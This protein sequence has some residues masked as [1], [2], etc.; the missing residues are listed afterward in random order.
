MI[1]IKS[2]DFTLFVT[3]VEFAPDNFPSVRTEITVSYKSGWLDG[4]FSLKSI[5]FGWDAI[6]DFK[7]G[8]ES[9]IAG[10]CSSVD[11]RDMSDDF[12]FTLSKIESGVGI[13]IEGGQRSRSF[14]F[15]L[16]AE[17]ET[18]LVNKINRKIADFIRKARANP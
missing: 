4:D 6:K 17:E 9:M 18:D 7:R 14:G 11:L 3:A 16:E 10:N 15:E 5:W 12:I 2:Q 1:D 13:H 8:V